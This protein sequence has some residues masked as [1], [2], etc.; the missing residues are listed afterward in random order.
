MSLPKFDRIFFLV[1]SFPTNFIN[2]KLEVANCDFENGLCT[3]YEH[4]ESMDFKWSINN[5][6]TGSPDTGPDEDHTDGFNG[7]GKLFPKL[8]FLDLHFS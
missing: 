7:K 3:G 4:D 2:G 1:A 8:F 5:G 6:A